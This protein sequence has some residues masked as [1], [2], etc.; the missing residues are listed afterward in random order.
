MLRGRENDDVQFL[1]V[2]S[3]NYS[4]LNSVMPQNFL[5]FLLLYVFNFL[6]ARHLVLLLTGPI[7]FLRC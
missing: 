2:I 3:Y 4:A 6:W 7:G 1:Q 5:K